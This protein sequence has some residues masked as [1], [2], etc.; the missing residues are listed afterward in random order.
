MDE[1][2]PEETR[3]S[4]E[5]DQLEHTHDGEAGNQGAESHAQGKDKENAP[6]TNR[7]NLIL[8]LLEGV[9]SAGVFSVLPDVFD[10]LGLHIGA[11]WSWWFSLV[12]GVLAVAHAIA[13]LHPKW[14]RISWH[15][16]SVFSGL[17]AIGFCFW[18]YRLLRTTSQEPPIPWIEIVTRPTLTIPPDGVITVEMSQTYREHR[19]H[20]IN[21]NNAD[22]RNFTARVQL[23]EDAVLGVH[24]PKSPLGVLIRWQPAAIEFTSVGSRP[25]TMKGGPPK[26][27]GEMQLD[28]DRLPSFTPIEI[29]FVTVPPRTNHSQSLND[30]K[31]RALHNFISGEFQFQTMNGWQKQQVLVPIGFDRTNRVIATPAPERTLTNWNLLTRSS[32]P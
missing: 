10:D 4:P 1:T 26:T 31:T 6:S 17:T 11:I 27:K 30:N 9:L 21:T 15:A 32:W 3:V 23:P 22:M 24:S 2:E 25:T 20:I 29:P 7:K 5:R 19:L 18:T 16:F 28:I 13:T 14:S 8:P 12:L